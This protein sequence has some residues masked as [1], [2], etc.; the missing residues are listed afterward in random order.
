MTE[1]L[2]ALTIPQWALPAVML[3]LGGGA[4]YTASSSASEQA[5]VLTASVQDIRGDLARIETK[6]ERSASAIDVRIDRL[7]QRVRELE[8]R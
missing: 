7:E 3:L 6:I 5:A 2:Q 1:Q 8:M 4:A